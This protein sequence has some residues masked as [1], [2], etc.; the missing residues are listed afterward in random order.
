[1]KK[2]FLKLTVIAALVLA[3]CNSDDDTADVIVNNNE[4]VGGGE[5]IQDPISDDAI[6]LSGFQQEDLILNSENEYLLNGALVMAS[7]TTLTMS[8]GTTISAIRT[9]LGAGTFI[10]ISQGAT[11]E[12]NGTAE[13]PVVLTSNEA[14]P[15]PGDWGGLIILGNAPINSASGEATSTSEIANLP[16]GGTNA[17]DNSGSISYLRIEYS[18]GSASGASE[19]NGLSLYGVGSDTTL[20]FIQSFAGLDDGIEF[21]GGTVNASNLSVLGAQDDSIDWTEGYSGTITDAHIEF[22]AGEHGNGI[23]GDGFNDGFGLEQ[24]FFS[25]PTINNLTI[26]G[27]GS[28]DEGSRG[29]L[30]RVGTEAT[31]NNVVING[32]ET[33]FN[34][35]GDAADAP[36]GANVLAGTLSATDVTFTDVTTVLS[37][38]T[39]EMFTEEDLISGE[40]NGVA[41][42]FETWGAG[43]TR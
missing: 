22:L 20:E 5:V 42:D 28:T 9:G 2:N 32:V 8:A 40:G 25:S 35:V 18:G 12:V 34:I 13:N 6:L 36:T 3:S 15:V 17:E 38:E 31:L 7:G 14:N 39:P 21:F 10:A 4:V 27:L 1:M 30:L 23:E 33:G 29:L 26:E 11:I 16:Y 37:N 19:N 24:D 41:T 43:W